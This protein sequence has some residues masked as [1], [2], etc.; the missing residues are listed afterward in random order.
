M[1]FGQAGGYFKTGRLVTYAN[2]IS[3][4]H[5]HTGTLLAMCHAMGVTGL[6]AVGNP[7]PE[8]QRGPAL[9]L[10]G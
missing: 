8:Y 1:I 2:D 7:A 3:A 4:Y 6:Q 10:R 5:K 9:E